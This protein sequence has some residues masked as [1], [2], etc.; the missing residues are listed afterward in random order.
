MTV[1][2]PL[3]LAATESARILSGTFPEGVPSGKALV[4]WERINAEAETPTHHFVYEL[5]VN[6]RR[7]ALYE[8]T[9]YRTWPSSSEESASASG[10]ASAEILVWNSRPGQ[11]VPVLLYERVREESSWVWRAIEPNTDRYRA[12]I[13]RVIQVYGVHR[14]VHGLEGF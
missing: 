9:R 10:V 2:L 3:L 8:I 11:R 5:W 4:G 14:A 6:P 1:L 7:A 12:E 13:Q